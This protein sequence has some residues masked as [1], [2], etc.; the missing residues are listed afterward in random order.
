MEKE[1][2]HT[3][4]QA[5]NEAVRLQELIKSGRALNYTEAEMLL[6]QVEKPV[7]LD[8]IVA[9][10]SEGM[11]DQVEIELWQEEESIGIYGFPLPIINTSLTLGYKI[12]EQDPPEVYIEQIGPFVISKSP[13]SHQEATKQS[14]DFL[15]P[16]GTPV[17]AAA[18]GKIIDIVINNTKWGPET[19]FGKYLNYITLQHQNGEYTQYCHLLS[20]SL[21]KGLNVGTNVCRGTQLA[22]TGKTGQ[23][24]RDHLH[25][26]VFRIEKSKV[27]GGRIIVNKYGFKSL[28]PRLEN[29]EIQ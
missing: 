17:L 24:D 11:T 12:A 25:F 2:R 13:E 21:S 7:K 29:K 3:P 9:N 23:T 22:K 20:E 19:K 27:I 14:L 1:S 8:E 4:S 26:M 10:S 18:D 15:V 28:H 5:E 16:D 6:G